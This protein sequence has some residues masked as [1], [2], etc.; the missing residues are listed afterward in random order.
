MKKF[1]SKLADRALTKFAK[2][3]ARGGCYFGCHAP[4]APA[5]LFSK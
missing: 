5:E 2:F 4:E 1:V 3:Q